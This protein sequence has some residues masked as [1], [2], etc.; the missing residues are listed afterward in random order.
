MQGRAGSSQG[1]A[2]HAVRN[3]VCVLLDWTATGGNIHAQAQA[4]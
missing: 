4:H 2:V 3:D 1:L